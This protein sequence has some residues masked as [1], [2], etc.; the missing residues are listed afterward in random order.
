M[1]A[2]QTGVITVLSNTTRGHPATMDRRVIDV[3]DL[4]ARLIEDNNI[5]NSSPEMSRR[6]LSGFHHP[7]I[8]IAVCTVY[9]YIHMGLYNCM[10][11]LSEL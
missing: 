3:V 4:G 5:K 7:R 8:L 11:K 10:G 1:A 9:T 6:L 2:P